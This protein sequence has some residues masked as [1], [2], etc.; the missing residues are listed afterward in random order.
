MTDAEILAAAR[1]LHGGAHPLVPHDTYSALLDV[2][3]AVRPF[4]V[5]CCQLVECEEGGARCRRCILS[6]AISRALAALRAEVMR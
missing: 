2:L 1:A 3:E 6:D 5:M 4:D